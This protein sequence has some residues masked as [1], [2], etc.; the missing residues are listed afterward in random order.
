MQSLCDNLAKHNFMH[1]VYTISTFKK[2]EIKRQYTTLIQVVGWY[3]PVENHILWLGRHGGT[4]VSTVTSQQEE[5]GPTRICLCGVCMFSRCS[6]GAI[7]PDHSHRGH[8]LLETQAG[9]INTQTPSLMDISAH[10][11]MW[12]TTTF[13]AVT[14]HV[15][16]TFIYFYFSL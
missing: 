12:I 13:T 9:L 8:K 5:T 16:H 14:L 15:A 3:C 6:A 4:V 11:T 1:H 2:L 10:A 7:A